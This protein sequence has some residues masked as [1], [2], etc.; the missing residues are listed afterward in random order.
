MQEHLEAEA[1]RVLDK[2]F[3][4]DVTQR[5][6]LETYLLNKEVPKLHQYEFADKSRHSEFEAHQRALWASAPEAT[7]RSWRDDPIERMLHGISPELVT[8]DV[9]ETAVGSDLP[10]AAANLASFRARGGRV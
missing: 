1:S 5:R 2:G 9:L 3:K 8:V 7:E 10:S 4:H 6:A